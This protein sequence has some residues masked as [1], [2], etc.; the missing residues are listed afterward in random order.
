MNNKEEQKRWGKVIIVQ[1][2]YP[3]SHQASKEDKQ[4]PLLSKIISRKKQQ[5]CIKSSLPQLIQGEDETEARDCR[6]T[7]MGQG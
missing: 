1:A 6:G 4:F 5:C 3:L 7:G 2:I